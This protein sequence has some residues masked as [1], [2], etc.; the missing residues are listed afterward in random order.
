MRGATMAAMVIVNN[1]GSWSAVYPPLRHAEWDG[2]TP[3]DLIFPFFLFIVGTAMAMPVRQPAG[4][5]VLRRT[6]IL[7]ALGLALNA[8]SGLVTGQFSLGELRIM[9]VL[10]RIAL[11]YAAAAVVTR[12]LGIRAQVALAGAVLLGYALLLAQW[13][14]SPGS[15]FPHGDLSPAGSVV[16]RFDRMVL[17]APHL[18]RGGP[19]DPEGLLSTIPAVVTVLGG[20]WAGL[21]VRRWNSTSPRP[22]LRSLWGLP[23]AAVLAVLTGWALEAWGGVPINKALWSSSYVL[24]TGGW[25]IL[26]LWA[27]VVLVDAGWPSRTRWSTILSRP[28]Q[29]LGVNAILLFVSSGLL[30]RV[31]GAIRIRTPGGSVRLGAWLHEHG[32]A[33]WLPPQTAS[34]GYAVAMLAFWWAVLWVCWRRGWV[35]KV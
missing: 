9:G 33:A 15:A 31:L 5:R 3:T 7:F 35:L 30:A 34:L 20:F 17:T 1:P 19:Q 2:C 26:A 11:C 16:A 10:Q 18:Y 4:A 27:C 8:S 13:P 21:V 29:I 22:P 28:L 24:Y 25:A 14:S 12:W 32:F 23:A 6:L